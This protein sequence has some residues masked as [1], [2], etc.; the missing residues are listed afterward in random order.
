M[1]ILIVED[2]AIISM[3]L[4]STLKNAGLDVIGVAK[5]GSKAIELSNEFLPDV[6]LMDV[7]IKGDINGIQ[8]AAIL[9]EKLTY[10]LI[11]LSGNDLLSENP[12]AI[13][14]RPSFFVS[15][16]INIA[17]LLHSLKDLG[18]REAV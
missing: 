9:N 13:A 15:K 16:P 14:T 1:K 6:I 3:E 4:K 2:N 12:D 18:Q 17:Q 7:G 10:H 8:T 5:T 11:Y